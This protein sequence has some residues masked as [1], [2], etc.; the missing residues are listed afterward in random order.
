MTLAELFKSQDPEAIALKR[1]CWHGTLAMNCKP[2]EEE[3]KKAVE[4]NS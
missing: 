3:A 1:A 2:C 4:D